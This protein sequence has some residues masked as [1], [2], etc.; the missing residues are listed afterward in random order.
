MNRPANGAVVERVR[1]AATV[2]RAVHSAGL[3][4][5][6]IRAGA[7]GQVLEIKVGSDDASDVALAGA[8]EVP[9][10][11]RVRSDQRIGPGLAVD[12]QSAGAADQYGDDVVAASGVN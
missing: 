5:E 11:G 7:A 10:C 3:E 12:R 4:D 6:R 8:D 1:A 2:D 9:R